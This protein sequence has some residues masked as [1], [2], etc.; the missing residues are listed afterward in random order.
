MIIT[1]AEH[2][3]QHTVML[4]RKQETHS[5]PS[6]CITSPEIIVLIFGEHKGYIYYKFFL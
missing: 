5:S 6:F 3:V 2:F 4:R 1:S